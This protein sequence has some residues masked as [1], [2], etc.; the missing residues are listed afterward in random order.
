MKNSFNTPLHSGGWDANKMVLGVKN[1]SRVNQL[2]EGW[3]RGVV[4][5]KIFG[6]IANMA[7]FFLR[8][9]QKFS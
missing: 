7:K 1:F 2:D 6:F 9:G 4:P 5:Q 8:A 3:H